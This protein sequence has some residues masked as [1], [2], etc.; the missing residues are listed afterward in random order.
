MNSFL[1]L[2]AAVVAASSA[3][4]LGLAVVAVLVA[5]VL[6]W[7]R[8]KRPLAELAS[9]S[10]GR[11][12]AI[13]GAVALDLLTWTPAF[14][15]HDVR[16][17]NATWAADPAMAKIGRL[18]FQIDLRRL[19]RG[20]IRV[21]GLSLS[22]GVVRLQKASDGRVNWDL[23][24]AD[25]PAAATVGAVTPDDR[26]EVPDIERLELKN[27]RFLWR[28]A[29][30]E[31]MVVHLAGL[32]ADRTASGI[33]MKAGGTWR[34]MPFSLDGTLGPFEQLRSSAPYPLVL[35]A[36]LRGTA[37]E[38]DGTV[39]KPLAFARIDADVGLEGVSLDH[40]S[41]FIGL[42]LP[43][44]PRYAI[45][46]HLSGDGVVWR[47]EGFKGR[48]GAS[49]L[50]GTLSVDTSNSVP[51]VDAALVSTLL[52]F[53]DLAGLLG[54]ED[55]R[56]QE[57]GAVAPASGGGLLPD[58][59]IDT[60]GLRMVNAN[61]TLEATDIRRGGLQVQDVRATFRLNDG[62]LVVEPLAVTVFGGTLGGTMSVDASQEPPKFAAALR[63]RDV[64]LKILT[65]NMDPQAATTG[66]LNGRADVSGRGRS[67]RE[68]GSSLEGKAVLYMGRG[69][70]GN[71]ILEAIGLDVTEVLASLFSSDADSPIECMI[72]PFEAQGGVIR[73][74]TL[75]LEAAQDTV[76]GEGHV[77]LRTERI[78]V[79]L[80]VY[81]HDFSLFN[82]PSI[83][84]V[85]GT[86]TGDIGVDRTELVGQVLK[87][88]L[89]MPLSPFFT[90]DDEGLQPCRP[91]R[92]KLRDG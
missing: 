30:S 1:R 18:A 55:V 10:I 17:A 45:Q 35:T 66:R 4:I 54:D 76:I 91:V 22:D 31:P 68:I 15:A 14:V 74:E 38:L 67:V 52:D 63:L 57:A 83:L 69:G 37:V 50:R 5:S 65:A 6:D 8:F 24:A 46:G 70:I 16:L 41:G 60:R 88:F 85:E 86:L 51:R 82:A 80:R 72:L 81:P 79:R 26:T 64:D 87:K 2:T 12:V 44:T 11:S 40:L 23:S 77:D 34:E 73:A 27:L 20:R 84:T 71:V 92:R 58:D 42:P 7:S 13:E 53:E 36:R 43:P 33:E 25:G 56:G 47:L 89:M 9:T 28:D 49:D 59:P 48:L 90:Q 61:I 29:H 62:W 78:E 3:A 19:L 75:L 32:T 21:L 39:T